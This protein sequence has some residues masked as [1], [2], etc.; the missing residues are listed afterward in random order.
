MKRCDLTALL[1]AA[2]ADV[3]RSAPERTI[4]L[5][6][7][8]Q[9]QAVP[10]MADTGRIT[11]VITGYLANALSYAPADQPVTVQFDHGGCGSSCLGP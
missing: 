10:I 9:E 11:R 1:R 5:Q 6:I 3:Q 7:T 8:S 2:V 4:V